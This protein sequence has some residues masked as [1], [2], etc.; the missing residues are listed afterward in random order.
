MSRFGPLVEASWLAQHLDAPHLR[1]I[2]FRWHLNHDTG[3]A[4]SGRQAYE[5]SHI[6]GSAFVDLEEVSGHGR[7]AGRHPLPEADVFQR[8]M[9]RAGVSRASRVVVYDDE[10]GLAASRLWW[11]LRYFGH[12]AAAVL[13]GGL[14]AWPGP[15]R[16]GYEDIPEGDFTAVARPDMKVNF[17][18]VRRLAGKAKLF[19]AR[20]K[21]RYLGEYEPIEPRAGHI[22]GAVSA[23]WRDN[24]AADG[25]FRRPEELRARYEALGLQEGDE[26]VSYCASGI[27]ACHNVLAMELAGLRGTRLYPG[28]WS[29]WSRRE[30]AP[31]TVG[32]ESKTVL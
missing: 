6:P 26:A 31:V 17:E 10:S 7:G 29:A 15:P 18:E 8:E 12:D 2:D 20:R 27:S 19:D 21:T 9:R 5:E 22:P 24:L 30:E 13:D 32:D 3:E 14:P 11:L 28:S 23:Y 25:R 1:I 4:T 16:S